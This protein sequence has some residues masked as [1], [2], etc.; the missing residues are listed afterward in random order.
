MVLVDYIQKSLDQNKKPDL[1]NA[2]SVEGHGKYPDY[3]RG[4]ELPIKVETTLSEQ[5]KYELYHYANQIKGTDDFIGSLMNMVDNRKEDTI[6]VFYGDH[7][8]ALNVFSKDDFYL[9]KYEAPYA[10][11]S[12][13]N[14][15]KE[16]RNIEAY[17]LST[18]MM[19]LAG[20]EYGPI[21][22]IHANKEN[23]KD[24][25]KTL[26]L[27]QYDMLFGKQYYLSDKEKA[28]QNKM[29]MGLEDITIENVTKGN[30]VT[31]IKGKNFTNNS[32][33][34]VDGK[35]VETRLIDQNT[36]ETDNIKNMKKIV[37]KQLG[38]Y[39]G[40]LSS[41]NEVTVK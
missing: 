28:K 14:I 15:P 29:K 13:F 20:V 30:K 41:T 27:V 21:E 5:D 31:T 11:Y 17:Q 38:K 6:V 35:K 4:L 40:E 12:N 36:L 39:D 33:I 37:V 7:M 2:I 18:L 34:Y 16:K 3:D 22:K 1:I 24:Y 25:Q 9:D 32:H 26:E 10:V 23:E 19:E 8:P